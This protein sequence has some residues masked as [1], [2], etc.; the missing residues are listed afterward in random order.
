LPPPPPTPITLICVPMLNSSIISMAISISNLVAVA[1]NFQF[2][3][4]LFCC[5]VDRAMRY[6]DGGGSCVRGGGG[7]AHS[8][9]RAMS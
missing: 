1:L 7:C 5:R 2:P 8:P 3:G 6:P 9:R 4:I